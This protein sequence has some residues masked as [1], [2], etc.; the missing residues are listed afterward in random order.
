M[1]AKA[2]IDNDPQYNSIVDHRGT[3]QTRMAQELQTN[4]GVP[5]DPCGIEEAK[6][7]QS[8]LTEYQINIVSKEYEDKIIYAGPDK[9]KRIYLYMHNNHYDVITKMPGFF[10]RV[11]YCHTCKKTY[12]HYENHMC[13][14]ACK[15]CGFRPA[16]PEESSLKCNDC[17][18]SFKSQQW[19]NDH[20][21][22]RGE[23]RSV[24]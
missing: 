13:A 8:Y 15:C 3:M 20:K 23:A 21:E 24:C 2:K 22:P 19:Y 4:A 9:D 17:H 18:R 7:F 12:D 5:L 10:A 16:C 6:R 14:D 11:Y 1:V